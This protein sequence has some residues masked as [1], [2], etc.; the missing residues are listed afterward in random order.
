MP[1]R[2]SRFWLQLTAGWEFS[3]LWANHP[4]L[5]PQSPGPNE[6]VWEVDDS[7]AIAIEPDIP[8][9]F[10]LAVYMHIKYYP[11]DRAMRSKTSGSWKDVGLWDYGLILPRRVATPLITAKVAEMTEGMQNPLDKIKVLAAFEQRQIRYA[12]I[13][14]GI[15]SFQPHAAGDVFA[16]QYGD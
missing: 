6:Y 12:A 3:T 16:H 8:P 11:R 14:I 9:W 10:T 7:P 1:V 2:K 15:G 13:E 4:E 5:K